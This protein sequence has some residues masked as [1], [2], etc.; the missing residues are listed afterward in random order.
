MEKFQKSFEAVS[1]STGEIYNV[2]F[3]S[4]GKTVKAHCTCPAGQKLTLCKHVLN[5]ID[6]HTDISCALVECGLMKIY[7]DHY[8]LLREAEKIKREA[9]NVKKKFER[10]LIR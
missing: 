6:E 8:F 7:E 3:I 1:E 10:L 2:T 4:D 9:K 5:C